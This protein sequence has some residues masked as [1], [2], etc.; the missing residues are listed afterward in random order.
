[1]ENKI[2]SIFINQT[3]SLTTKNNYLLLWIVIKILMEQKI[4]KSIKEI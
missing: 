4:L 2:Q 3:I 1:M